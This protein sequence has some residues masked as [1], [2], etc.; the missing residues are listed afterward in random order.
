MLTQSRKHR[1]GCGHDAALNQ[2]FRM[3]PTS[4]ATTVKYTLWIAMETTGN[5]K[6]RSG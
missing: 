1:H 6:R 2:R 5:A 4:I 3:V